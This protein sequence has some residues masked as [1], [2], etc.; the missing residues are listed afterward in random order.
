MG[1]DDSAVSSRFEAAKRSRFGAAEK[2]LHLSIL[3]VLPLFCDDDPLLAGNRPLLPLIT[4]S[5]SLLPS[6]RSK[7]STNLSLCGPFAASMASTSA[8]SGPRR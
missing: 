8:R 5:I 7:G 2:V 3:V 4:F 6:E 1:A